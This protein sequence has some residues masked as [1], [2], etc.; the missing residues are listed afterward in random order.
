MEYLERFFAKT[1]YGEMDPSEEAA[2]LLK[3]GF[4]SELPVWEMIPA[5]ELEDVKSAVFEQRA[6]DG[7][8]LWFLNRSLIDRA[9]AVALGVDP[10]PESNP[11]L[12]PP[13]TV[14]GVI[15]ETVRLSYGVYWPERRL[16]RGSELL[17][18]GTTGSTDGWVASMSRT[19]VVPHLLISGPAVEPNTVGAH[20]RFDLRCLLR[21]D[22]NGQVFGDRL[23]EWRGETAQVQIYV[24]EEPRRFLL[25]ERSPRPG[26]GRFNAPL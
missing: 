21:L 18:P 26:W 14:A 19:M 7:R 12:G 2:E 6:G 3:L 5:F 16:F 24:T 11:T 25:H 15:V 1:P 22:E 23:D 10:I 9:E 17:P 13:V 4:D 8:V 20:P